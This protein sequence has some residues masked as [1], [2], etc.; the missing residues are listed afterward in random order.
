MPMVFCASLEPWLKPMKPALT[1]W[2]LPNM[3]LTIRGV[4][5][6]RMTVR[7]NISAAPPMKPSAGESTMGITIFG[8]RPV[9]APEALVTD[10]C[11]TFQ[12]P[13]AVPRAAPQRP[14]TSA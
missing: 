4:T 2:A 10:Q 11:S 12:L 5:L 3:R 7:M 9:W 14:P 8:Q 1:S 6:R 13:S